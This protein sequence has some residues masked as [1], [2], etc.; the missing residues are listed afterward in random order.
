MAETGQGRRANSIAVART[1]LVW[2]GKRT[3]VERIALPFQVV[4]TINQSRATREQ[5]PML[6]GLPSPPLFEGRTATDTSW[7]N[8]LI[9]GEN[10]YVMASLLQGDPSIGLEPLAGKIDL[11]YIDPP[12]ATGQDFSYRARVGDEEWLK[13]ASIIEETAYRD[14][15][16]RGLESYLQM[17]YE[18]LVVMKELLADTGSA[19]VHVDD[20][21]GSYVRMLLDEVFGAPCYVNSIVWKRS[22]AHSDVGQGAKHLGRVCDHVFYYSR[23]PAAQTVNM[24][25]TPLPGSTVEKWYR[26]V[27][28]GTGRRYNKADITGP[29]GARKGNPVYDWKGVTRAWRFSRERMEQLEKEGRIVY[30][31][32][33]MPY[34]KRY[35]DESKG[36]PLQDLWD[37]IHMIRG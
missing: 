5:M 3:Q 4:E 16:G 22:D 27:E 7:R 9:W 20:N 26:H 24:Q 29:G 25:F 1:E 12:F 33:G 23:L 17:M 19:Y 32:S 13:E 21:V 30:S 8:K 37:D 6:A 34:L 31:E 36:V 11:I 18:R 28:E 15:W 2:P 14:T 10:R 35:L